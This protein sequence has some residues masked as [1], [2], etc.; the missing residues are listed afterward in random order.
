MRSFRSLVLGLLLLSLAGVSWGETYSCQ[1]KGNQ[2][3]T[4]FLV[5]E[6]DVFVNRFEIK[7]RM[8]N[9]TFQIAYEDDEELRLVQNP[10]LRGEQIYLNKKTGDWLK[11]YVYPPNDGRD[12]SRKGWWVYDQGGFCALVPE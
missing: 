8:A 6:D 1:Y 12:E 3:F 11:A 10:D 7:D 5:R 9:F 4:Q 2:Q